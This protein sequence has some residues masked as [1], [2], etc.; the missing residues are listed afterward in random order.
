MKQEPQGSC[1]AWFPARRAT[2]AIRPF[3]R[4]RRAQNT[5]S[6]PAITWAATAGSGTGAVG[7]FT[8][9]VVAIDTA[10]PGCTV[11]NTVPV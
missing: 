5:R 1:V 3:L 4:E 6:S 10:T 8:N 9:A 11:E 7:A 2:G